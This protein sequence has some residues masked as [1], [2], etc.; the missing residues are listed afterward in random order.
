MA[1][2]IG[3]QG[4]YRDSVVFAAMTDELNRNM[5]ELRDGEKEA[6]FF[7]SYQCQ[8][9]HTSTISASLGSIY[10]SNS[11]PYGTTGVRVMVGDYDFNDESLNA[12]GDSYD[13]NPYSTP[14]VPVNEDYWG[15]R[16]VFW[17]S[18]DGVYR[19][20]AK[21][22]EEHIK[23]LAKQK[24]SIEDTPHRS[25]AKV[26]IEKYEQE[27]DFLKPDLGE[28]ETKLRDY[29][30][31]FNE[32]SDIESSVVNFNTNST[33]SY[34]I[35]SE[36]ARIKT[37][38]SI[39]ELSIYASALGENG[40]Q[41]FESIVYTVDDLS[42][43]PK[44]SKIEEDIIDLRKRLFSK[45]SAETYD[46]EYSGPVLLIGKPVSTFL[47]LAL[48]NSLNAN[49]YVKNPSDEYGYTYK[50][51]SIEDEIDKSYTNQMVSIR[52]QPRLHRF[53]DKLL[54]G[55]YTFDNEGVKPIDELVL[56]EN[57]SL[58]NLMCTRTVAKDM[59]KPTGTGYGPGVVISDVAKTIPEAK[60]KKKL[61]KL[62]KS[63]KLDYAI[64]IRG[65]A[66]GGGND[67]KLVYRVDLKTGEE[68]LLDGAVI[69]GLD[70]TGHDNI[71]AATDEKDAYNISNYSGQTVSSISPKG[72]LLSEIK[73][74]SEMMTYKA[75]PSIVKNP[76]ISE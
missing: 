10:Y 49:T 71:I 75:A 11:Y 7:I 36:G 45:K 2:A 50:S 22:Y 15:L 27:G 25:F 39:A 3:A 24:V 30:N 9:S 72:L 64:I 56:I 16:K 68:T 76:L 18:T 5:E 57:G 70:K 4:Q 44:I 60:M 58:K 65:S 48:A 23:L 19:S 31:I 59:H 37:I 17:K 69:S 34:F 54:L 38:V 28:W 73:L 41:I 8:L 47:N 21:L 35:S 42:D 61:I 20:A 52:L 32:F 26:Q 12:D 53:N 43:M 14:R 1:A 62:C 63:K 46:D 40:E 13:Y 6:P 29:S 67:Q 66:S 55:S 74:S 51:K 33:K